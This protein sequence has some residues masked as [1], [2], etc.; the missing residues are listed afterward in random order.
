MPT[1]PFPAQAR[2]RFVQQQGRFLA[3][4]VVQVHI[5]PHEQGEVALPMATGI[6]RHLLCSPEPAR[7]AVI[8]A[9]VP[10]NGTGTRKSAHK[11][12]GAGIPAVRHFPINS[13]SQLEALVEIPQEKMGWRQ[14]G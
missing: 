5:C 12:R 9:S 7:R 8:V 6:A 1:L 3:S 10:V 14:M 11:Q 2:R 13:C 4:A